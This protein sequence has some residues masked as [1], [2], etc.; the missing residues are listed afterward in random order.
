M[1][2]SYP[3]DA[4]GRDE[5]I[6]ARRPARA[7]LDPTRP[8]AFFTEQERSA[9]GEIV[10]VSTVFLTNRE[11]PWRCVMCDLWRNSLTETVPAGAIPKQ[12]S[13]ALGQLPPA[14]QIKLYNGGSFFDRNAIP[15]E[16]YPAIADQVASFEQTIVESHPALIKRGSLRFRDL[17]S[18]QLEVAMGLETVH[19]EVLLRLNKRMTLEQF[20]SA[21]D[22]L[23]SNAIALRVFI[24]V[25]PP[26]MKADEALSWAQRSLDFAFDCGATAATLIPTRAGN[27]AMEALTRQG[28]FALPRIEILEAALEYGISRN[29][30]RV[31][32]DLWNAD[33]L[34]N[35]CAACHR[36][37][38]ER[39]REMN[40]QQIILPLVECDC[41][42][43]RS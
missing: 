18:N 40:L 42:E 16:D 29:R 9:S 24:L 22:Y 21:A 7:V 13:Y 17:L 39:L 1:A 28:D 32:A 25:Q 10:P 35:Q 31:F 33:T 20:S 11:C 15:I 3:V 23:R 37:R 8:Y 41:D 38:I 19:P 2:P 36:S 4:A 43:V 14:R 6:L 26:F 12:I 34:A 27:G 30:G 5:W